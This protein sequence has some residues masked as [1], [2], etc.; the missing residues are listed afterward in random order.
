MCA[1]SWQDI[2][3][4]RW[5]E[6]PEGLGTN[7]VWQ[8]GHL[9]ISQYFAPV[10]TLFGSQASVKEIINVKEYATLFGMGSNPADSQKFSRTVPELLADLDFMQVLTLELLGQY[11]Y[12][13]L[14]AAPL[15]PRPVGNTQGQC[16][17][18][19]LQHEMWHAGQLAMLRKGLGYSSSFDGGNN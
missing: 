14:D 10:V 5:H 13:Q 7:L 18:W 2:P 1:R 3:H 8:V 17:D 9:L 11:D 4:N 19:G 15:R 16:L 6:M 12:S